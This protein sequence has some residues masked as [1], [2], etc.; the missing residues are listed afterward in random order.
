[1]ILT[2]SFRRGNPK[3][4]R[5]LRAPIMINILD[6][7][8]YTDWRGEIRELWVDSGGYQ[9][10]L[11]GIKLDPKE[12]ATKQM[13][14]EP[15]YAIMPDNPH[16]P[17]ITLTWYKEYLK[18]DHP[19]RVVPVVHTNWNEDQFK[20]LMKIIRDFMDHDEIIIGIGGASNLVNHP[21]NPRNIV[22][23]LETYKLIRKKFECIH[24]LGVGGYSIIPIL[25]LLN[26]ESFDTASWIHD[27][28]FG[29][30]RIGER[31][32]SLKANASNDRNTKLTDDE[33][34]EV[35]DIK[36]DE[37]YAMK[38]NDLKGFYLRAL[39]NAKNLVKYVDRISSLSRSELL[40]VIK[41]KFLRE[42]VI[43]ILNDFE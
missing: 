20:K 7:P 30:I 10:L 40:K 6:I 16:N 2:Y 21:F 13:N 19:E 41:F 25:A 17:H 5:Y 23:F 37:L 31:A 32:V 15:D 24:V 8:K 34:L 1:V 38:K 12:I 35:T 28:R 27:A 33:I 42:Y 22:R 14:L 29:L 18:A 9:V 26:V 3:I 36:E 39:H 11:R 4:W 43:K